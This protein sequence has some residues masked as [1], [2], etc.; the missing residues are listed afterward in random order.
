M[1]WADGQ[2]GHNLFNN[3]GGEYTVTDP[4]TIWSIS[5]PL[6]LNRRLEAERERQGIHNRSLFL[7]LAIEAYVAKCE[8]NAAAN[9]GIL[10]Q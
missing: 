5:L 6:A 3:L 7:R 1:D 2:T 8:A 10:T 4:T 9:D